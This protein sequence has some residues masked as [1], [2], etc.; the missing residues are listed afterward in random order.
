MV[1]VGSIEFYFFPRLLWHVFYDD[2]D[3]NKNNNIPNCENTR[4]NDNQSRKSSVFV[5]FTISL[6]YLVNVERFFHTLFEHYWPRPI[7]IV[8]VVVVDVM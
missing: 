1:S 7:V 8:I 3:F 2:D 4:N 6:S 5:C